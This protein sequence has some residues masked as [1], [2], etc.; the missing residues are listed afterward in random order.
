MAVTRPTL[1]DETMLLRRKSLCFEAS[2]FVYDPAITF[3]VSQTDALECSACAE[4]LKQR[5]SAAAPQPS[6]M[7]S[8]LSGTPMSFQCERPSPAE[9]I[10]DARTTR[11]RLLRQRKRSWKGQQ[12]IRVQLHPLLER[13]PRDSLA[14]STMNPA[15][16]FDNRSTYYLLR[17][18][19]ELRNRI[20]GLVLPTEN[21]FN[22]EFGSIWRYESAIQE[23][24][25]YLHFYIND[26]FYW[27]RL[28]A[29]TN[30]SYSAGTPSQRI[31]LIAL[32]QTCTM[33][34]DESL[35]YFY[36]NNTF[37]LRVGE[38]LSDDCN[39]N[40]SNRHYGTWICKRPSAVIGVLKL[41]VVPQW[42]CQ[43][44]KRVRTWTRDRDMCPF[45]LDFGTCTVQPLKVVNPSTCETCS[46]QMVS[47]LHTF[48]LVPAR[49]CQE[50][51]RLM[52][53][54]WLHIRPQG[55]W[56][57]WTYRIVTRRLIWH[58]SWVYTFPLQLLFG[59]CFI[60]EFVRKTYISD[61]LL[62]KYCI[63]PLMGNFDYMPSTGYQN[64]C[65]NS[66]TVTQRRKLVTFKQQPSSE[67][68]PLTTVLTLST[69]IS[70]CEGLPM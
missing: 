62:D 58:F 19:P 47:N 68:Q 13:S 52:N 60:S 15:S 61:T 24:T 53:D 3:S 55:P 40:R 31:R 30:P 44:Q 39:G 50:A 25:R 63:R 20:Y 36:G 23:G 66:D 41:L 11:L 16:A 10:P 2:S 7:A 69:I 12:M 35:R 33:I 70:P 57:R 65:K 26:R 6:L 46:D 38:D 8:S 54:L 9:H 28:F 21:I 5:S 59:A 14:L 34:R 22:V 29:L 42:N 18:R 37:L 45:E 17:L 1:L 27:P 4:R 49:N 48:K 51:A 43:H 64:L 67:L 32:T 56:S